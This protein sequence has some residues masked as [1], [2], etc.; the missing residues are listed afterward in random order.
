[1][2]RFKNILLVYDSTE[3]GKPTLKR[4]ITLA[5]IN[6][7]RLTVIDVIKEIPR[8]YQ[9]LMTTLL[10]EEIMELAVKEQYERLEH[11]ITPIREAGCKVNAKVLSGKVFLEIIRE[12]LR[13][14]HDLVIKTARGK[15]RGG[16]ILFGSTAMHL[17]RKCPCPVWVM[18]PGQS[19]RYARIL[20][21]VDVT[22]SDTKVNK[23]NTKIMDLATS[24]AHLEQSE[25]HIVH[26]W[27]IPHEHLVREA[28]SVSPG[29]IEKWENETRRLPQKHL[30]DFLKKYDLDKVK[31]QVHLLKG[32]VSNLIPELVVN[33]RIDLIVMG[34]L[35]RTGIPGFLIGNTAERILHRVDCSVLTVKPEGFISPVTIDEE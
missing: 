4:A 34:T 31:F 3:H 2:Q 30:D 7:A 33:K 14:K 8:D 25:L 12:V 16:D 13:N 17:M 28:H 32:N 19:Q 21:A 27:D 9:M 20:A 22:T 15:R 11:Y 29:E 24:L 26:A 5:T 6:R 10:P 1:M 18:K 35:C 23:L